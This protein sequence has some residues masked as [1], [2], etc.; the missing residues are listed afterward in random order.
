MWFLAIIP[1]PYLIYIFHLPQPIR[2][3]YFFAFIVADFTNIAIITGTLLIEF[4]IKSAGQI[5]LPKIYFLFK[6]LIGREIF[7]G[8]CLSIIAL[9]YII[10]IS[11]RYYLIID[12]L[13]LISNIIILLTLL[14]FIW[15]GLAVQIKRWND[16]NKSG[17][18]VLINLI[19][20]VGLIWVLTE[21]GFLKG[22]KVLISMAKFLCDNLSPMDPGQ[23]MIPYKSD[24][25]FIIVRLAEPIQEEMLF[26]K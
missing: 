10:W 23:Q 15:I 1:V 17:W 12:E 8:L 11:Y 20:M 9:N 21:L 16:R 19:P 5:S 3:K 25:T 13:S 22:M 7:C 6:G 18:M 26:V 24:N 2:M 4:K 14:L